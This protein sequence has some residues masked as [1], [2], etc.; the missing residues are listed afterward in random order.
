MMHGIHISQQ[1]SGRS[2]GNTI[3]IWMDCNKRP[4]NISLIHAW[5]KINGQRRM[6]FGW[7]FLSRLQF[8]VDVNQPPIVE[9]HWVYQVDQLVEVKNTN[10]NGAASFTCVTT[11][12]WWR[13]EFEFFLGV[14]QFYPNV[15]IL[16]QREGNIWSECHRLSPS[17]QLLKVTSALVVSDA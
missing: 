10:A 11:D 3:N 1:S 2:W 4:I 17:I 12:R 14:W 9:S 16:R 6:Q 8:V 13:N 15:G 5:A 7:C